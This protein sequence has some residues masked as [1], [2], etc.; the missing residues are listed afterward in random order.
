MANKIEIRKYLERKKEETI[1]KLICER[2]EKEKIATDNFFS[3]YKE[4]FTA[5]KNQVIVASQDFDSILKTV[6]GLGI[7]KI[8][9]IHYGDPLY[10]FNDM[11]NSLSSE[12]LKKYI[13]IDKVEQIRDQYHI[14][15]HDAES[16]YLR[17]IAVTKQM[18][19]KDGTELLERLGFDLSELSVPKEI[20][21]LSTNI[22]ANKLFINLGGISE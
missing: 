15:I 20:T 13:S 2:D 21:A 22:D 6:E 5:I 11:I 4:N 16:E 9:S 7:A 8:G 17:L 1:G 19:A 18:S 3:A 10:K 14:L 12:R